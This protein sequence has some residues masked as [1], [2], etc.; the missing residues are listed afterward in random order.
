ME[1]EER[2]LS[3]TL[4]DLLKSISLSKRT[5]VK[6]SQ[7]LIL[8][9]NFE[10]LSKISE[11][12]FR[13]CAIEIN[14]LLRNEGIKSELLEGQKHRQLLELRSYNFLIPAI[15]FL[16]TDPTTRSIVIDIV[17]QIIYDGLKFLTKRNKSRTPL[18]IE[19]VTVSQNGKLKSLKFKGTAEDFEDVAK[20]LRRFK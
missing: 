6:S 14:K 2:E 15:L 7:V 11:K 16:V 1:I 18:E 8:P 20:E 9:L 5:Y 12:P 13:D 3:I 10:D 19:L 17:S 4:D